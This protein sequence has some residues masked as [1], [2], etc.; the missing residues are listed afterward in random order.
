MQ[1]LGHH[2]TSTGTILG[3]RQG[4]HLWATLAVWQEGLLG[5]MTLA[6]LESTHQPS[7]L[8]MVC[9]EQSLAH[10]KLASSGRLVDRRKSHGNVR[11]IMEAVIRTDFAQQIN[12]SQRI[13]FNGIHLTL[14]K[15]D[16]ASFSRMAQFCRSK[17]CS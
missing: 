6:K 13:A 14:L 10:S 9:R 16:R 8:I 17:V 11:T 2:R 1:S 5:E 15:M 12:P 4:T 7:F 3:M